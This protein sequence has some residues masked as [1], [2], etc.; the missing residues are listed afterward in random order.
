MIPASYR[1]P[2]LVAMQHMPCCDMVARSNTKYEMD[3]VIKPQNDTCMK[4]HYH[5]SLSLIGA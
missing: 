5:T 1:G 3:S 4:L 2:T